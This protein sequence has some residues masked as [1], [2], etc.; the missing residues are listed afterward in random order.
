MFHRWAALVLVLALWAMSPK[1]AAGQGSTTTPRGHGAGVLG[2]PYPNPF[3]PEIH[4]P[5]A[6]GESDC[7][8]VGLQHEVS[9]EIRNVEKNSLTPVSAIDIPKRRPN[10]GHPVPKAE[11][12][13]LVAVEIPESSDVPA[14]PRGSR[15]FLTAKWNLPD[16]PSGG[17]WCSAVPD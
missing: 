4:I 15:K 2:V 16:A 12:S 7:K 5:F 14:M 3:N 8:D 10:P 17:F 1:T 9:V 11:V 6:V 13:P